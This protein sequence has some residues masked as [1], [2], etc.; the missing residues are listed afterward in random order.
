MNY[1]RIDTNNFDN[2]VLDT[3]GEIR[4]FTSGPLKSRVLKRENDSIL[5][6]RIFSQP[7][8]SFFWAK[9]WTVSFAWLK[10]GVYM[11]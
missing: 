11:N 9:I 10:I 8:D 3:F 4:L 2:L 7:C 5:D 6:S 1:Q